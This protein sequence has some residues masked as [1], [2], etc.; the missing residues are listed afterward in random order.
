MEKKKG[1]IAVFLEGAGRGVN[2]WLKSMLPG[3]VL[4][5]T[6][7]E[8]MKVTGLLNL[9]S[10]IFSPVMSLFGLP[11]EA[12][13]ILITAWMSTAGGCGAAAS[14]AANGVLSP[15]QVTIVTPMIFL[16]GSQLQ[17]IGRI[18]AVADVESKKYPVMCLIG[19]I[20]AFIAGF[21]MRI[22]V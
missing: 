14:L 19:I 3:V 13:S 21:I 6:M 16:M 4:G 8:I 22:I 17:F 1:I 20:N 5:Y 12:V 10:S 15:T 9:L 18:L 11:G 2:L 7:I